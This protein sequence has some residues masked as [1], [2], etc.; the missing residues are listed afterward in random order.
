MYFTMEEVYDARLNDTWPSPAFGD[1]NILTI[2]GGHHGSSRSYGGG[3]GAGGYRFNTALALGGNND[4][5]VTVGAG[6]AG[7]ANTGRFNINDGNDSS[8]SGPDIQTFTSG[9]GGINLVL[10]VH[11]HLNSVV[12]QKVLVVAEV[13]KL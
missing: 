12:E 13:F 10:R 9:G 4:Y 3:G 7:F 1:V 5:T 11:L 6:G 2:G 8:F